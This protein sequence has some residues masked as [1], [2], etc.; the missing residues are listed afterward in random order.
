VQGKVILRKVQLSAAPGTAHVGWLNT[1]YVYDDLNNL[2]FVVQPR[3]VDLINGS[4][5][6]TASIAFELC[7]RYE[8]DFRKRLIIKKVPGAGENWMIYDSRDRLVMTQDSNLRVIHQWVFTKYDTLNRPVMNGLYTDNTHTTQSAMQAFLISQNL[9]LCEIYNP[10]V[11]PIYSLAISFPAVTDETTIRSYIFYDD[12][13]WGNWYGT[14]FVGKDNSYDVQFSAVSNTIYPYPQS[15]VQTKQTRGLPTGTINKFMGQPHSGTILATYYDDRIRTIQTDTY[16]ASKGVDVKTTQYC[17][18]DQPL[19]TYLRAQNAMTPTQVHY[20]STKMN[21]DGAFRLKNIYKN[22]DSAATDQLIDSMQYNE[23]GQLRTKYLGN[24]VDSLIY[25]Y[26]IRGWLT[27]I[28]KNYVGGTTNHYFGI[29]LGYDKTASIVGTT[30]Y[31]NPT[32]N[33]NISGTI[34]KSAGDGLDRKYDFSYDN[35]DRLTAASFLQNTSGSTWD[36]SSID[37]SVS[38]LSYDANGNILAMNQYGFKVGGSSLIDQL[39]YTYVNAGSSNKLQQ[40]VD[41]ANDSTSKLGDFHYN[42]SSK[43]ST[44]YTYDGNGNLLSDNNKG[45]DNIIYNYLNLPQQIHIKGKGNITYTYDASGAKYVKYTTDS[46]SRHSTTIRYLGGL[47]YQQVDTISNLGTNPDTLQFVGHEEGRARLAFHKYLNGT[48]A[49][50]WEYDFIEKDHLGNTRVLLT[51][52]KDTAQYLATME[53]AYRATENQLFYNIPASCYPRASISGYP[54]DNTTV[55]NDSVAR[56]NGNGQKVGAAIILKVMF[57]DTVDIAAKS[58]YTSQTGTGTAPSLTDVLNSLANGIVNMTGG[59]KGT[60]SQLN[61]TSGPL[62]AALNSFITNKDGTVAGQPRAYLN[63]ILLDNQFNYVSSYPQSGAIPVS[64]FTIGTLGTPGYSGIPITKSG[65]LYIYVSNE[66]QGWDVFFDNLSVRQRSGPVLEENHFYPFGLS[67]AGISDK[68]LKTNY[69]Q[70]KYRYNAKELQNQEFSDGTG[71]EEYDY[72]ARMQDPQLGIWHNI[73]PLADKSRRW[74]PYTYAYNNPVNYIDPDGM[75]PEVA[76]H[77]DE[78][79]VNYITVKNTKTGA[80]TTYITGD[81]KEGAKAYKVEGLNGGAGVQFRT[82]DEAA[83]AWALE[84]THHAD[85]HDN[86]YAGTIYSQKDSKGGKSYSYNGSYTQGEKNHSD[87]HESNIPSGAAIEGLIHTHGEDPNFSTHEKPDDTNQRLDTDVMTDIHKTGTDF[88]LV[89]SQGEFKVSRGANGT[90]NLSRG[91]T[92]ILATGL[93]TGY[94]KII[95]GKWQGSDGK[96]IKEADRTE[97]SQIIKN[98]MK[99]H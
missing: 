41:A 2:R 20:I 71:L 77:K 10:A 18:R 54:T 59:A 13:G 11:N 92:A 44:D 26:N 6:I 9:G 51:Q 68:A 99:A 42:A 86:E 43:A 55:P 23:L 24:K 97:I 32:Y 57:G 62:Y 22:I 82:K 1:Y 94:L 39:S 34:W 56:L 88:Y 93:N 4:W 58:Y 61:S 17:F 91:E 48:S 90:S 27:G 46:I 38:G 87:Y 12:Y 33:G 67:M 69:A 60:L 80:I 65:Y 74:S 89:N 8:Y 21:Y 83:F 47:V 16:N 30:S 78:G 29:E 95:S 25:D 66:T 37:F 98:Y 7:F 36:N 64:N 49:Y 75:D 96:P 85:P 28:N 84:N 52:E 53:A 14:A 70:N 50:R 15:L 19:H 81:A 31:L 35:V 73:D 5:S 76:Q 72:G 40:V 79:M 45:I 3:A 63:W